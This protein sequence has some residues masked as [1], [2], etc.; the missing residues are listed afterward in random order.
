MSRLYFMH[1]GQEMVRRR[2]QVPKGS[3]VEAWADMAVGGGTFWVG[4]GSKALLDAAGAEPMKA[5]LAVPAEVV[6]I[7]YGPH[8][9]DLESLPREES[10]RARVLSAHAIA[11]AW[12][13]LDP[14]GQRTAHDAASPADPVFHLRRPG[15]GAGTSG[16]ASRAGARQWTGCR[17][18]TARTQRAPSGRGSCRPT[19]STH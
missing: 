14:S 5:T 10:L 6:G 2:G 9:C 12:I 17:R 18:P 11:V 4:E 8:L 1:D 16:A 13:T 19:T 15:G 7:F 3:V